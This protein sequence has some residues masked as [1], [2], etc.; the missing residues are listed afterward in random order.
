M[1]TIVVSGVELQFLE[2]FINTLSVLSDIQNIIYIE[3]NPKT[4]QYSYFHF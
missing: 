3:Y 2:I 1:Q 4:P